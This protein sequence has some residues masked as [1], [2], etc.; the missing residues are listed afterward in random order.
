MES[1][2]DVEENIDN[3]ACLLF[4]GTAWL[5]SRPAFEEQMDYLFVDE[6]GQVATANLVAMSTCAKNIVLLGDQMQLGQPIQGVHPGESGMSA[7]DF[8]LEGHATI[9]PDRGVFLAT[10]WRMHPDVC[11]FISDAVYESRLFP[12]PKN[13]EQRLIL[14]PDAHTALC[15]TGLVFVPA[16][17][18]A[19]LQRSE[20]EAEIVS[21]IYK[22]LLAQRYRDRDGNEHLMT[23]GNIL[24]VAPYNMQVNLLRLKTA[25]RYL[26]TLNSCTARTV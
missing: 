12:E 21:A 18:D 9:P 24:V 26:D 19:C 7:L 11:R 2:G 4:A 5:F 23:A 15:S 6:A 17:H 1:S 8:L 20:E 10:T 14:K 13:A 25:I 22:S 16:I 3:P